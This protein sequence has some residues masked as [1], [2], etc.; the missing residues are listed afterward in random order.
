MNINWGL[1]PDPFPSIKDKGQRR[2]S[3]LE[4]ARKAFQEWLSE[5]DWK[6]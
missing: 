3:K 1:L 4:N 5:Q 6:A 2:L